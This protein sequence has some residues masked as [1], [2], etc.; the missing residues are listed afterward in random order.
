MLA[1]VGATKAGSALSQIS[2][3]GGLTASVNKK[4]A[5]NFQGLIDDLEGAGYK[6]KSLGGY[7]YRNIAG[8]NKLSNHAYGNAIDINP[9]ANPMGRNLVTDMPSS[10]SSLAAQNGLSWGGDWKSKK[11]AMH[12]EVPSKDAAAALEKL[13]ASSGDATMG[14]GKL[15]SGLGSAGGGA[16]GG[17]GLLSSLLGGLSSYGKSAFSASPQFASAWTK[18]GIGL[19]ADGGPISGPGSGTSD[20]IPTMLSDGE[21]VVRASQSKKHRALLHAIN[22]GTIG[23]MAMGGVARS[24]GAPVAPALAARRSASN[25]NANPGVLQVQI[26]GANG[27][28]HVRMLVKQGVGEGLN[29]YNENQRRGGFG[30]MQSRYG[31][32]KG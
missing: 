21:F 2:T 30:T 23:H 12:F 24:I 31:N 25:D 27:D 10:V 17:G 6:I 18:G 16:S 29:T 7:N 5:E 20:S 32:Q 9:G 8:T 13:A 28:D 1:D 26:V 22:N 15:A 11:D 3:S 19:Y 14:L 4:F